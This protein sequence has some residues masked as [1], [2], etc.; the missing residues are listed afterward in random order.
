VGFTVSTSVPALRNVTSAQT[1]NA[2]AAANSATP[3]QTFG[4]AA[5][6]QDSG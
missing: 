2:K 1:A 3:I 5:G 4:H 6:I